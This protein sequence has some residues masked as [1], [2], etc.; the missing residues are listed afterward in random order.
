MSLISKRDF[1]PP[2]IFHFFSL[3]LALHIGLLWFLAYS[4]LQRLLLLYHCGKVLYITYPW[5]GEDGT[6]VGEG[7]DP[8]PDP[9]TFLAEYTGR[10]FPFLFHV[11]HQGWCSLSTSLQRDE[12]EAEIQES[13]KMGRSL[14]H[15]TQSVFEV[16]NC[17]LLEN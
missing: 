7:S 14:T 17:S 11:E 6:D 16:K 13:H 8:E 15:F 5:A 9:W 1:S 2:R 12:L 4:R 10:C 3:W